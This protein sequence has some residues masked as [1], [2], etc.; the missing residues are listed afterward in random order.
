[1]T[2]EEI[3]HYSQAILAHVDAYE[4]VVVGDLDAARYAFLVRSQAVEAAAVLGG[5]SSADVLSRV[6]MLARD[7][8]TTT[9]I[10][11]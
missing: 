2:S 8:P 7:L 1:M 9:G 4:A 5:H 6:L 10:P 3:R 11:T